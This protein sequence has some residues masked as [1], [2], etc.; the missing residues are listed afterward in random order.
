MS[1]QW[2]RAARPW[3]KQIAY[4]SLSFGHPVADFADRARSRALWRSQ[5]GKSDGFSAV[6]DGVPVTDLV[7]DSYLRFRPSPR[8]DAA[9]PFVL[10][11]IHQA[12]RDVRRARRYFER[13]RPAAYLT[14]FATYLE[15]GIAVR[16]ALAAGV[17]VFLVRQ[18]IR[19]RQGADRGRHRAHA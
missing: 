1:Y 2:I 6:I 18:P 7:I 4:R 19:V 8:F 16:V 12:H 15:H 14:S 3:I 5:R 10:T 13:Q 17:R 11:L 9:D